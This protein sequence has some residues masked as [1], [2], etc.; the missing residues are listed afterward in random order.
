MDIKSELLEGASPFVSVFTY[1]VLKREIILIL[2]DNPD[3]ANNAKRVI[4]P[5]VLR[6]EEEIDELDDE[7]MESIIGMHWIND[8]TLCIKLENREIIVNT[9]GK[10]YSENVA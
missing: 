9:N 3:Q 4:I 5:D 8:E 2:V 7:L 10:P 1:D 6:Y